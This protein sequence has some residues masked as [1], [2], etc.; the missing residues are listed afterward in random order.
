MANVRT[1][2]RSFSGGEV[3]PEFFG[4]IDDTKFQTGLAKCLNFIPLPHGPAANRAGFAY[5]NAAKYSGTKKVRLIPFSFSTTQTMVLE[6]GDQYI[7]F[8]TQGATLLSGASPYEIA[9]PY[10]EADLFDIHYVQSA[11]VLTLVHPNYAPRE[12]RRG[13]PTSWTLSTISFV[14]SL[15]APTGVAVTATRAASP[16]NLQDYFYVVTTVGSTGLD[17]SLAS[18]S[19]QTNQ[20]NNLLQTGAY[21]TITWTAATGATRY[22]VY[23][24]SNGLF[25]YVGETDGLTFKD[26]NITADLSITPPQVSNPFAATGDYP[27]TVS[28]HQQRRIFAGT[29]NK[30]QN[31]WMTRSGTESNLTY[32]LPSRDD[33][34][35]AIRVAA[36]EANTIRHIVPLQDIV[37]LTSSAEWRAMAANSDVITPTTIAVKPQSYIG[38]NNVQPVT[39]NNNLIYAAARGG[40]VREMAYNWQAGGF[41]TG[42]LSLR[43]PHLF[44]GN[45]LVDMAYAKS[46]QPICWFVSSTGK[47]LGLTYVPEQ[48]VGAWHQHDTDGTFESIA[49]VAEADEDV[50]YAVVKRTINGSTVRYVERMRSRLFIDPADAFFVDAGATYY[51]LGSFTR[52]GTTMTCTYTAH[53][54]TN[55]GTY[56]FSFSD[57]T[58]G[59]YRDYQPYVVTVVNANTFTIQVVNSGATSGSWAQAA[60]TIS[61]LSHLEGETVNILADAAVHPQ[62]VVTGGSITLDQ[63]AAKVQIGLPIT[64]DLQTLPLAMQIDGGFGQGRVKNVNRA[65]LRV[66]RSSGIFVG[67][68]VGDLVEAKQRTTEVYGSPP[69]L[70]SEEIQ[71]LLT[72]S[73]ADSGQVYV[74]QSDPLP[75]TI[76]SMT[77]E[78]AVGA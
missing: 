52:S 1:F 2:S 25:G 60:I 51:K 15:A 49:V 12:L 45:T 22:K 55:G 67:P 54:L 73:W 4:R 62:R 43:A 34:A 6:L 41:V 35:I 59:A 11:D 65:W 40:H 18:T 21:N 77:L 27:G 78:V 31:L 17:E 13:G 36:R 23:K 66:Y 63:Y 8:H 38:A 71:I 48:Q 29:T 76:V 7:R 47:L 24:Q 61:G 37:L 28:Y 68:S 32:S 26:D 10:L 44:D 69:E 72:P 33:D 39:V 70:K 14:P 46:P 16:T 58:F 56:Y 50:L 57:T 20:T 9:T 19:A 75:L 5:V 42:D 3:T 30:P 74:R 53:G 64:A